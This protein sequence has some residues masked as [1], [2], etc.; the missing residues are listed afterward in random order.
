[1]TKPRT[2]LWQPDLGGS[3]GP[4]Y[5]AIVRVLTTD[6]AA[7]R[8]HP[9]DRL[10]THRQLAKALDL[11][12]GTVTRAYK[13]AVQSGILA[14]RVGSGTFVA[15]AAAGNPLGLPSSR[16]IEMSVD[17]PIHAEDPDLAAALQKI[18]R[19]GGAQQL[20]RYQSQAGTARHRRAGAAWVERFDLSAGPDD[21]VVCAGTHHALTVALMSITKP[22]DIV[23][24]D[25][26][27]YPGIRAIARGL[28]VRLLG[29]AGD[30]SGISPAAVAAACKRHRVRALYTVPSFHNPTTAQLDLDRR[31]EL[32]Q[33]AAKHDF[34]VL[35][36]D[37]HRLLSAAPPPP[38][39]TLARDR[40]FYVASFSKAVVAGLRVAFLVPPPALVQRAAEAVWSTVWTV[41]GLPVEVAATWIEDGTA[42]EVVRRKRREAGER[43]R[44]CARLLVGARYEA[45]PNGY[46]ACLHLPAPW[47]SVEFALEARERGVAVTPSTAFVVGQ[48]PAPAA[49]RVCAG[50][51]E[52]RADVERGLGIVRELLASGPERGGGL[53]AR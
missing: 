17:L 18:A 36:D 47:T 34:H 39:A 40:T 12:L 7:G 53:P 19:R 9:G 49:V 52:T 10:P 22:G 21:I 42:D 33:L 25:E 15:E 14:S 26:L 28:R 43:Q 3:Q 11:G 13:E 48:A 41:P 46:Y 51:P 27:S 16:L 23:L 24:C 5:Q 37:V 50:A 45:Q 4:A 8:L 38:I 20:L 31:R 30:G 35:E 32:A 1:M 44:L 2:I 29:I 6:I